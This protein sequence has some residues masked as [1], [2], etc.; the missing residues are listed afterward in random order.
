MCFHHAVPVPNP[1]GK[2][3]T[4]LFQPADRVW[5]G[6]QGIWNLI[7]TLSNL[8]LFLFLPF[9]YL[10]CE[11]EGF[12]GAK[13]SF[14]L[15]RIGIFVFRYFSMMLGL[16]L[17]SVSCLVIY[18]V[19]GSGSVHFISPTVLRLDF[20]MP[21]P[22]PPKKKEDKMFYVF[23][24]QIFSLE[25]LKQGSSVWRP[26]TKNKCIEIFFISTVYF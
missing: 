24:S 16:L 23:K 10:L 26:R 15:C 12:I 8:A 2:N 11:S 9:A 14:P 20:K 13:V 1:D 19:T 7:F 6:V 21:P 5:F 17:I 22:P 18:S 4:D 25:G 3:L